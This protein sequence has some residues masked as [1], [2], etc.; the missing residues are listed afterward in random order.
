MIICPLLRA[1]DYQTVYSHRTALFADSYGQIKPM[2]IDSVRF[3]QDSILYPFKNIQKKDLD[4]YTPYG[5]SW[6]GSKIVIKPGWNYFFNENNDTIRIKTDAKLNE[7]WKVFSTENVLITGTLIKVDLLTF[8]GLTDSVRTIEFNM[9]IATSATVSSKSIARFVSEFDSKS[10]QVSKH[11]GLIK[12]FNFNVFPYFSDMQETYMGTWQQFNLVGLTN[13]KVGVQNL[14]WLDIFDFQEG[15]ELHT[16]EKNVPALGGVPPGFLSER[17]VIDKYIKR[18]NFQDS[19]KYTV[20]VSERTVTHVLGTEWSTNYSHY[21]TTQTV[22]QN[23]DFDTILPEVPLI[24]AYSANKYSMYYDGVTTTKRE[25]DISNEIHRSAD[26]CWSLILADGCFPTFSFIKGFGGPYYSC[27]GIM[28]DSEEN[29]LVYYK[30]GSTVWGTPL[31]LTEIKRPE[32]ISSVEVYPNP[33]TD[34]LTIRYEHQI[35]DISFELM[36]LQGEVVLK[37]NLSLSVNL[38]SLDSYSKGLYLYRLMDNG[39]LT[40]TGKIVKM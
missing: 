40:K 2:L 8:M 4:C 13:P 20:E 23:H 24:N 32:S 33:A 7:T 6:L 36:N 29:S 22:K 1:Y 12:T 21:T 26:S 34:K 10:I 27:M 3:S 38:V 14:T 16:V 31:V 30:K 28:G 17:D 15:D 35:G 25:P 39:K 11:Y 37:Q 18:Q 5:A 19:I 9:V